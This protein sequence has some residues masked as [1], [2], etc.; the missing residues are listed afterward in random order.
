MFLLDP[1]A[2]D[3]RDFIERISRLIAGA[4][5]V[6]RPDEVWIHKIDHWFGHK[7][8]R[9]SGKVLGGL[10]VWKKPL[11]IPRSWRI[12]LWAVGTTGEFRPALDTSR[13]VPRLIS[14]LTVRRWSIF[15]T[16]SGTSRPT[17]PCSGSAGRRR[18]RV[19]E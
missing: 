10:G 6:H 11:T 15:G 8:V 9:F 16:E 4:V 5:A 18:R 7:W 1:A 19:A 17:R 2:D 12:G 3:D 14:I 13:R